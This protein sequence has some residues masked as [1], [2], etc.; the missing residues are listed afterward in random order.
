LQEWEKTSHKYQKSQKSQKKQKGKEK[1]KMPMK[2][3]QLM[4][5]VKK[6]AQAI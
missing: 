3:S 2:K 6:R 4:R 5:P 1:I